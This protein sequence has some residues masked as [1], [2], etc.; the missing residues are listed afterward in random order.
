M[1]SRLSSRR[2]ATRVCSM[3]SEWVTTTSRSALAKLPSLAASA[4]A[5]LPRSALRS[6]PSP[7]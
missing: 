7:A 3:P 1:S 4:P 2:P 5:K 6:G